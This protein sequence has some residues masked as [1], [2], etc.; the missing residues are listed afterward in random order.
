MPRRLM[1]RNR[2]RPE[3]NQYVVWAG[4][5]RASNMM[6]D[7][8]SNASASEVLDTTAI[9][10]AARKLEQHLEGYCFCIVIVRCRPWHGL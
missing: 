6:L 10:V 5:G 4:Y 9:Q 7:S 2:V 8:S 3:I 1:I